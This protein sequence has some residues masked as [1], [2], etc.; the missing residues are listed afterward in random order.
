MAVDTVEMAE[1]MADGGAA[2][3]GLAE[4][5]PPVAKVKKRRPSVVHSLA[6]RDKWSSWADFIMSCVGYAIGLGNV[7][8]FPYLCYQNGG[9]AFLIPYIIAIL[10]CGVPLFILE[11]SWG[12]LVSVGG[13][14]MFKI[15]PI[16]KGVGIAAVVM[17]FWLNIYYIVVLSWAMAYLFHSMRTDSNVPWRTCNNTWN[18][19]RCR[20]E[21]DPIK[22]ES[23][24]SIAGYF[25]VKVDF[26]RRPFE[27]ISKTIFIGPK[28][29]FT[30]C[31]EA[32][33]SVLS[34][35]KEFWDHRVLGIS[36]GI[37]Q[38][39]SLRQDLAL[40]LLLC[41][42]I[43]Y[44]C[45]FKGV[46]WTG[47][48]VYLTASFPYLMLFCL[49]MRG[50]SL[51]GASLGLEFYLKPDFSKLLE[52]KVWVDAVTQVFFSYG[53]GVGAL[54]ALGSYNKYHNNVYKQ[55]L[56]VCCVNSGTSVFAGF[57]I[58]SFIGYM[59]VQQGKTVDE[60]AQSGPGLLFLAYPSGILQLPYTNVW[61]I[62]FFCM[63]LFL[64]IDSQFC[65]MEGF[66]T[67]VIDEFPALIRGRRHG[68]EMFVLLICIVSYICGLCTVTEGG[69]YMFQ[70]FDFYAASGW[71]LLWL[72]FFEC[73][74]IS[75]SVGINRWYDHLRSMIGYYPSNWWKF[76]WV[77]ATPAVCM[78][79]MIFGLFKYQ[80]LR[81]GAYNYDYPLWGHIFGWCLSLSSMLC[82]PVYA[83][84]LWV[85]TDGTVSEKFKK[86]FR[87]DVDLVP[88]G[89]S[90]EEDESMINA[91]FGGTIQC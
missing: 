41:W 88:K 21:Y 36:G 43:C 28:V 47:K 73:I 1:L 31:T 42:M 72:L 5:K 53:L 52:S 9:G 58:F 38:V 87:P 71:A 69:F 62:L 48:V 82:I 24:R 80:P 56:T 35:V 19:N 66:F 11:T 76:C 81:I 37:E 7:W 13:L 44:F 61:S 68:R 6:E 63:V 90:D 91:K 67:A 60:V 40:Y 54:V 20:S 22:C 50:L 29:N 39:G 78:G 49:L 27:R 74:A 8:R 83:V 26:D 16:F 2:N 75:W 25:N 79:V 3:G 57:V 85:V 32:D 15:C 64:G 34:P 23:N 4:E 17:A 51:P 12:Q 46:K 18:S 86:L 10:F 14:G 55:A 77:F 65:T 30:I 84:Y 59:A 45:I 33:L 89:D 70:L